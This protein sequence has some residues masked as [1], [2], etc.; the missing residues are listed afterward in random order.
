MAQQLGSPFTSLRN[1]SLYGMISK[2]CRIWDF[3]VSE[4]II[5]QTKMSYSLRCAIRSY[6]VSPFKNAVRSSFKKTT[7]LISNKPSK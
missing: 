6:L 5:P 3:P 7:I 4:S 2:N 1:Q